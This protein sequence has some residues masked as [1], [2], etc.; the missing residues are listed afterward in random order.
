MIEQTAL[1]H[2]VAETLGGGGEQ[3]TGQ[4]EPAAMHAPM[5]MLPLPGHEHFPAVQ[6]SP[7]TV[8]SVSLQQSPDGMHELLL[9]HATCPEGQVHDFPGL[10]HVSPLTVQSAFVQHAVL[11]MHVSNAVQTICPL[12]HSHVAPGKAHFWPSAGQS[13][14]EQHS[15]T[16]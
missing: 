11:S 15:P 13:F 4:H 3:L 10:G 14:D 5:H 8:Q 6:V 1:T 2:V 12:G 16:P 7:V 9:L